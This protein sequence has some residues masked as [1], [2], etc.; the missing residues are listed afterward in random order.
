MSIE[1]MMPSSYL[2]LCR[3]LL[4]LPP[5]PLRVRVFSS[6][7]TLHMRWPKYWS[8]R[9]SIIP[10]KEIPRLIFF[11]MDWLD[12]LAVQG[13]SQESIPSSQF[14]TINSSGLSLLYG[15]TLPLLHDYWKNHQFS[16][17]QFSHSVMSDSLQPHELQHARPPCPSPT[18]RVHPN[19]CPSS[20]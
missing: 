15:Q 18:P 13:D 6:E 7:S 8:F 9:F 17:V 20:R 16:S 3:P 5:I 11:R 4:L 1:S 19:S 2:I 10:S 12:L 14:K